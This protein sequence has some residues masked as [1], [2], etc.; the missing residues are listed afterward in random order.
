MGA[1]LHSAP[2]G[3]DEGTFVAD[4]RRRFE[5]FFLDKQDRLYRGLCLVTGSRDEAEEVL[6]DAFLKLWEG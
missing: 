2:A 5:D 1:S 3:S 6:Q 4:Q